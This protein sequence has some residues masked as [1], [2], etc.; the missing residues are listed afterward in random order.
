MDGW[1][2]DTPRGARHESSMARLS[3]LEWSGRNHRS[4][5]HDQGQMRAT[6]VSNWG[7]LQ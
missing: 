4:L 1:P 6:L 5:L 2:S 3:S 7:L